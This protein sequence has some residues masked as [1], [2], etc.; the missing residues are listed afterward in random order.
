MRK[1]WIVLVALACACGK[2]RGDVTVEA[3]RASSSTANS[4]S[5]PMP[6]PA[7]APSATARW[8]G[9]YSSSA[10]ALYIPPDW[11]DV[12]WKVKETSAGIGEGAIAI[13]VD[14]LSG[15]VTGT[16]EGPLG[17]ATIDGLGSDGGLS[18][19]IARMNPADEGFTG[20][21]VAS[22]ANDRVEG[23]MHV[24]LADANAIRT[25]T[26]TMSADGTMPATR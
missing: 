21:I 14:P 11:K 15:R 20:T 16:L 26:F 13:Q 17:P 10:G 24:S 19:S 4:I 1:T 18:A 9:K 12:H 6:S 2:S 3:S 8:R 25:A 22:I 5:A 23:T 7:A